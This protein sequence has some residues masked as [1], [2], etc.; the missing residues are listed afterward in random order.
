MMERI[1]K[2]L[3]SIAKWIVKKLKQRKSRKSGRVGRGGGRKIWECKKRKRKRKRGLGR[4]RR[5]RGA[6]PCILTPPTDLRSR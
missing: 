5:E 4:G 2:G 1:V 6:T 3:Q